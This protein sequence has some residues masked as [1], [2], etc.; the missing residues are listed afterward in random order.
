MVSLDHCYYFIL[1]CPQWPI[2]RVRLPIW[3]FLRFLPHGIH[4]I[5]KS[6]CQPWVMDVWSE[7]ETWKFAAS[8]YIIIAFLLV[9]ISVTSAW[10]ETKFLCGKSNQAGCFGKVYLLVHSNWNLVWWPLFQPFC[11]LLTMSHRLQIT[12]IGEPL[13]P[14]YGTFPFSLITFYILFC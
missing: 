6:W 3:G 10:F 7:W 13:F 11:I 1:N 4:H 9:T 5:N 14:T 12:L 8:Q 2:D